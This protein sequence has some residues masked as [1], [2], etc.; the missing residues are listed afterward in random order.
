[1]VSIGVSE[2][3]T[4]A[5]RVSLILFFTFLQYGSV[6]AQHVSPRTDTLSTVSAP[7]SFNIGA[8]EYHGLI[9]YDQLKTVFQERGSYNFHDCT[10]TLKLALAVTL[11]FD[12]TQYISPDALDT[13]KTFYEL[14][15]FPVSANVDLSTVGRL[16]VGPNSGASYEI[17]STILNEGKIYMPAWSFFQQGTTYVAYV[18]QILSTDNYYLANDLNRQVTAYST[19]QIPLFLLTLC[20]T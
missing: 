15:I 18:A 7:S 16:D 9:P 20:L 13:G 1:M 12:S 8:F 10:D 5:L 19:E 11:D 14:L 6:V 2:R 17:T 4:R 3:M